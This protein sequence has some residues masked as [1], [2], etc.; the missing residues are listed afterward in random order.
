MNAQ[1]NRTRNRRLGFTLLL[2]FVVLVVI[3]TV[4]II[5]G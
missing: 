3:A 2:V 4:A 5:R 1:D